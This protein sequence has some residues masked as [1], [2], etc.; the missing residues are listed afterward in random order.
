MEITLLQ[1]YLQDLIEIHVWR[2]VLDVDFLNLAVELEGGA[3][4]IIIR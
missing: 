4:V 3:F 2:I 1:N